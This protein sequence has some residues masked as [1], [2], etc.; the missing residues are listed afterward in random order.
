M[1]TYDLNSGSLHIKILEESFSELGLHKVAKWPTAVNYKTYLFVDSR[2]VFLL[3]KSKA[4]RQVLISKERLH[5]LSGSVFTYFLR[6]GPQ[7]FLKFDY[8]K[9]YQLHPILSADIC[10]GRVIL[11]RLFY[12][13]FLLGFPFDFVFLVWE[14]W[15]RVP[16][17]K[18]DYRYVLWI[19]LSH[20]NF[21]RTCCAQ[22][23]DSALPKFKLG[24]KRDSTCG[25]C[26]HKSMTAK[27]INVHTL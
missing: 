10:F 6:V 3:Q 21:Y 14:R 17:F 20:I 15:L 26:H 7:K 5:L 19:L 2:Y 12:I 23:I 16:Y 9:R 22:S 8:S 18:T 4:L 24:L 27:Q 25:H 11:F 13:Q 1:L